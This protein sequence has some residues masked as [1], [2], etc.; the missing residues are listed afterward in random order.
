MFSYG[1]LHTDTPVLADQQRLIYISFV[2]TLDA[3]SRTYKEQW[4]IRSNGEKE[5]REY[6][7]SECHDNDDLWSH[8]FF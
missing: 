1:F 7:L 3:V 4:P 6:I 2:P 5:S 8:R